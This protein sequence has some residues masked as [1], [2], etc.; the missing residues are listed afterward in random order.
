MLFDNWQLFLTG[1]KGCAIIIA[2]YGLSK[3]TQPFYKD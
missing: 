1:V 2:D 3:T